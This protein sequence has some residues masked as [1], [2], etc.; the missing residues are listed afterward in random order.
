MKLLGRDK[1][2]NKRIVLLTDWEWNL[3]QNAL[4]EY[5]TVC[6]YDE[7]DTSA[8]SYLSKLKRLIKRFEKAQDQFDSLL[9]EKKNLITN[10]AD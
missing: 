9:E 2:T 1:K 4:F 5:Q 7:V 8:G 3:I 10:Q 6:E